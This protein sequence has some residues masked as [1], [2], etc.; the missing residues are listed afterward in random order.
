MSLCNRDAL[1]NPRASPFPRMKS[2]ESF[3]EIHPSRREVHAELVMV[4]RE[5]RELEGEVHNFRMRL[6]KIGYV[7]RGCE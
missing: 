6:T 1:R 3:G 7:L 5:M 4:R 2:S